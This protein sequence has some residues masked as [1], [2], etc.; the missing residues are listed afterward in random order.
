MQP[1]RSYVPQSQQERAAWFQNFSVQF[2]AAANSLGFTA[3]QVTAVTDDNSDVQFCAAATVELEAF[4]TAFRQYR[5]T[6]MEGDTGDPT[7]NYPPNPTAVPTAKVPTGIFERLDNLVGRIRL[8]PG[9]TPEIG[10]LLGILPQSTGRPAP[11]QPTL[12]TDSLPGSVVK[13]KFV[14]GESDGVALEM[15]IDNAETWSDAGRFYSSPVELVIPAN[16]QNLP[17]AVQFRARYVEG[18]T[19]VGLFSPVITTATLPAG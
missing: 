8:S 7:V 10:A 16:A 11:E 19:P 1:N 3:A 12:K 14:R 4:I 17:R 9:Y 13:V 18:N 2:A 6:L 5:K 15:K